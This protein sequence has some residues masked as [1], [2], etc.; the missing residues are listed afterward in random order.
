MRKSA[1]IIALAVIAIFALLEVVALGT[2]VD[3]QVVSSGGTDGSSENYSAT[4]TAGQTAVGS[5]DSDNYGLNHGFWQDFDAAGFICGDADAT[6]AVDIDDVVWLIAYIF[7]GGPEPI[8]YESGD[9]NCS[10]GVDIDDVVWLISYIFTGGNMPCD[11]DGDNVP[12][13]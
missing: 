9:A 3:W 4:G 8:P 11:T 5:G 2:K 10:G 12:D 13:C 6:E 1:I 7:S